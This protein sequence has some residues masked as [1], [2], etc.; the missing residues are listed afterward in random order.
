MTA[1]VFNFVDEIYGCL[2]CIN[3]VAALHDHSAL[4]DCHWRQ[5]CRQTMFLRARMTVLSRAYHPRRGL[6]AYIGTTGAEH[7]Q[8]ANSARNGW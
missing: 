5:D 1:L 3:S 4:L 7:K 8:D 6:G 2:A